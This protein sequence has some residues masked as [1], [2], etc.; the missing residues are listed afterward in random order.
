[1][2]F[3]QRSFE[4]FYMQTHQGRR[5]TWNHAAGT[6]DVKAQLGKGEEISDNMMLCSSV[7]VL[8]LWRG[9]E[10]ENYICTVT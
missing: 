1:M 2:A 9:A 6:A 10:C 3:A 8:T 4:D 7:C 5:L